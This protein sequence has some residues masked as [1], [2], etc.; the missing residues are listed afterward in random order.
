M[1]IFMQF[2]G[3]LGSILA[4]LYQ[5][6]RVRAESTA[7]AF[8]CIA[9]VLYDQAFEEDNNPL[10]SDDFTNLDVQLTQFMEELDEDDS[11][12]ENEMKQEAAF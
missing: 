3:N 1:S 10:R 8:Q 11:C 7:I 9:T 12:S 6:D 4:D 2:S 5:R